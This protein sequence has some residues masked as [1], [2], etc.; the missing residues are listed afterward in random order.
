MPI[1]FI[2]NDPLAMGSLP[3]RQKSPRPNRPS[4]RAGFTYNNRATEGNYN[5]GTS[6]FL[7]WQCREAALA[8]VDVWEMLQG[9]LL[10]WARARPNRRRLALQQDEGI[11][12]NAYYDGQSLRFFEYTGGGKTTYSG[13]STDVVAHEAGHGLLDAIRPDL[14]DVHFT[15]VGAFH[16]AFGDC[17]ALL[18]AFSDQATRNA[19]LS[20]RIK[21]GRAN[22][23]EATAEDLADGVRLSP[24]PGLGP[25][26]PAA[27]PRHG[28]RRS[29]LEW[30][31]ESSG[32]TRGFLPPQ[33]RSRQRCDAGAGSQPRGRGSNSRCC[34]C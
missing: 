3:M 25:K 8:A 14:W 16:E 22:F 34:C 1:N 30:R 4:T 32:H 20:P 12:L 29:E 10:Q 15:E 31:R 28:P 5:P 9:P 2:P 13:A 23:V 26:H 7:F 21:L 33:C 19:L 24:A 6:K 27:V 18:T 17:M 11:D